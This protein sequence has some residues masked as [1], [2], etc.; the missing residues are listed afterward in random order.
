MI[1]TATF[2]SD[3]AVEY[4]LG[5]VRGCQRVTGGLSNDLFRLETT[6]GHFALKIMGA[7]AEARDFQANVERAY[8]IERA[9]AAQGVPCP[10]P[11]ERPDGT[12]M[13]RVS[14]RWV[15][16]HA[17]VMGEP[18]VPEHN[19]L[20]AGALLA[21]I[22][23]AAKPVP[24][25]LKDEPWDATRWSHLAG[26]T[27]IPR[28]IADRLRHAASLLAELEAETAGSHVVDHLPSHGDL[29]P[30]NTLVVQGTL[31]A[32][33]WD[34]AGLRPA[35]REAVSVALDWST[36]A[37]GFRGVLRSYM[38]GGGGDV[39]AENWVFGGWVSALC[40][41]LVF[42]ASERMASELGQ[43]E[44]LS[45]LDRLDVFAHQLGAYQDAL[46][47]KTV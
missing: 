32:V 38:N 20:E 29:D 39:P 15:R 11:V 19:A 28:P 14:G 35:A 4:D 25:A 5:D 13:V 42:N 2:L 16:V 30:K 9:A 10:R 40:G 22:H 6:H 41:W 46:R 18:P 17:W 1:V 45:T 47:P 3:V 12:C 31:M 8:V 36:T 26:Q 24:K 34:A 7:N 27:G 33:D 43:Q 37:E 23:G 21:A 44:V